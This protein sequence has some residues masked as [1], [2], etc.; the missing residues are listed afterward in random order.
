MEEE[1]QKASKEPEITSPPNELEIAPK[2]QR[3]N[4]KV[5]TDENF[6]SN[7]VD[8]VKKHSFYML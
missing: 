7:P 8:T 4:S 6:P 3:K 1:I 5:L 2:H